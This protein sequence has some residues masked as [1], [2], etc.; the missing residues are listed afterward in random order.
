MFLSA[1]QPFQ[2]TI[3]ELNEYVERLKLVEDTPDT[4]A[5]VIGFDSEGDGGF[6]L[7]LSCRALLKQA[8]LQV[9]VFKVSVILIDGTYKTNCL[10]WPVLVLGTHDVNGSFC[11]MAVMICSSENSA[12]YEFFMTTVRKALVRHCGFKYED[13]DITYLNADGAQAIRNGVASSFREKIG[14]NS[15]IRAQERDVTTVTRVGV[16]PLPPLPPVLDASGSG[17]A[18][19]ESSPTPF[20]V[21]VFLLMCWAHA[22][23]AMRDNRSKCVHKDKDDG[24]YKKIKK[25][26]DIIANLIPY[27]HVAAVEKAFD[28]LL[29]EWQSEE[30]EYVEYLRKTYSGSSDLRAFATAY[31]VPGVVQTTNCLESFNGRIKA[32]LLHR[33]AKIGELADEL[34]KLLSTRAKSLQQRPMPRQINLDDTVPWSKDMAGHKGRVVWIMAQQLLVRRGP[35]R[36]S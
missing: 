25:S 11:L 3:A 20:C 26:I 16:S 35:Y 30:P 19:T 24:S 14:E 7:V 33:R 1:V 5:G 29:S 23:R 34:L 6:R 2:L 31:A 10:G 18:A 28:L 21:V 32:F 8:S 15:D 12:D 22:G 27:P 17:D 13:I 9:A 36:P 4:T